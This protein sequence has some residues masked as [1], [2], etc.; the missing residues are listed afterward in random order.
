MERGDSRVDYWKLNGQTIPDAYP[1]PNIEEMLDRLQGA[2]FF[3]KIDL[4]D[5]F[6]HIPLGGET[7]SNSVHH[8]RLTQHITRKLGC[9]PVFLNTTVHSEFI[10][11]FNH[12]LNQAYGRPGSTEFWTVNQGVSS[13]HI[14][15]SRGRTWIWWW[16]GGLWMSW[17]LEEDRD[18]QLI[19]EWPVSQS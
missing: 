11:F 12:S 4:T 10:Q 19:T 17:S 15:S 7:P 16:R 14:V 2:C 9:V 18:R 3:S 1:L 5:G 8:A 13:W 6:W